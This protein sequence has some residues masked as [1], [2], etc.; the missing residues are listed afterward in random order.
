M[1]SLLAETK[2]GEIK[3][4]TKLISG[5]M[6]TVFLVS[7]MTIAFPAQVSANPGPSYP[8]G[9]VQIGVI[10][11]KGIEMWD[12][13]WDGATLAA[14][15]INHQ[16][17]WAPGSVNMPCPPAPGPGGLL[18]YDPNFANKSAYAEVTLIG[19][20]EH[21]V[22]TPDPVSAV[23]ELTAAL[24]SNKIVYLIGGFRTECVGPMEDTVLSWWQTHG[25]PLW[26]I[27]GA[28]TDSLINPVTYPFVF[29]ITPLP[30]TALGEVLGAF[31]SEIVAPQMMI[32][33]MNEGVTYHNATYYPSIPTAII[34]EDLTWADPVVDPLVALAPSLGLKIVDVD[35]VSPTAASY[36]SDIETA[37]ADGAKLVIPVFSSVD[38]ATFVTEYG[39]IK[40][41]FCLVGINPDIDEQSFWA[42]SGGLCQ[43]ETDLAAGG[44][45][46]GVPSD[47]AINPT[48]KPLTTIAF[49]NLY[50]SMYGASP[51]YTA[52]G[53][54]DSI[55][56]F[57][58]TSYDNNASHA[59]Y[60]NGWSVNTYDLLQ[61]GNSPAQVTANTSALIRA[62]ETMGV[63]QG[64]AWE[65]VQLPAET[66]GR[67]YRNSITGLFSYDNV[68]APAVGYN[69]YTGFGSGHDVFTTMVGDEL[70]ISDGVVR[71][72]MQQ[73][74]AGMM[75]VVYPRDRLYS[76]KWM[77]PPWMFNNSAAAEADFAG[78]LPIPTEVYTGY[79]G[80][81]TYGYP[82]LMINYTSPT[83][84]VGI[85]DLATEA[86]LWFQVPPFMYLE[87]DM[88]PQDHFINAYDL[89]FVAKEYGQ[90]EK[91]V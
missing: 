78:G 82:G 70:P 55:I 42:A 21:S 59:S 41:D 39:T 16:G 51:L 54:W 80:I 71:G 17:P 73:W 84:V 57:S 91:L 47:W 77:L 75:Q 35:R 56:A 37:A 20:D 27:E 32:R 2:K 49:W 3:V 43:W 18:V 66:G 64:F 44:T 1:P 23:A 72:V 34:A 90:A 40:P 8:A 79:V 25:L 30:S 45:Q 88:S 10:G 24:T 63:S 58:E 11:P 68:T 4:K 87:A 31:I 46:T 83:G 48:A 86:G 65:R 89:A 7:L 22:P 81:Y 9:T 74:Q 50:E 13:L 19:I 76:K 26:F 15:W 69:G 5:I 12:A 14:D 38:G 29:R 67:Y 28:A 33:Y 52:F 61:P 85:A 62:T 36:V 60:Q 6:A 53:S